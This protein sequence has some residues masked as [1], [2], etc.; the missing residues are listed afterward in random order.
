MRQRRSSVAN[1]AVVT[2]IESIIQ[3]NDD[4]YK[5]KNV[6][7]KISYSKSNE[8]MVAFCLILITIIICFVLFMYYGHFILCYLNVGM[9]TPLMDIARIA[10]TLS[11]NASS[12]IL[13]D[14]DNKEMDINFDDICDLYFDIKQKQQYIANFKLVVF[15]SVLPQ[16]FQLSNI[17]TEYLGVYLNSDSNKVQSLEDIYKEYS[18]WLQQQL[19]QDDMNIYIQLLHVDKY[20][21]FY[22]T[23]PNIDQYIYCHQIGI[24]WF[25][26]FEDIENEDLQ[27]MISNLTFY[28]HGG[29][30]QSLFYFEQL[31]DDNKKKKYKSMLFD[32]L[33]I[34]V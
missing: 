4:N 34:K 3:H 23:D 14:I 21:D 15:I 8:C 12:P 18:L 17:F 20:K 31:Q 6:Q 1:E 9:C 28:K 10:Y 33:Q 24:V 27:S 22:L 7:C 11:I 32:F 5:H 29:I 26:R 2:D 30:R 19:Q 25:L 13:N 16:P